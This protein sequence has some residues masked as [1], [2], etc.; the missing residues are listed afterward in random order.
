M[1]SEG[2]DSVP[3]LNPDSYVGCIIHNSFST[4]RKVGNVRRLNAI[5]FLTS[6]LVLSL[7]ALPLITN[8]AW[9][10]RGKLPR[11]IVF[12]L[13]HPSVSAPTSDSNSSSAT[14]SQGAVFSNPQ[15]SSTLANYN[16]QFTLKWSD[17][18]GIIGYI[19]SYDSG[20]GIFVNDSYVSTWESYQRFD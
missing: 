8:S 3:I 20:S 4:E 12:S 7:V 15:V 18:S 11:R 14:S 10:A 16:T 17:P 6:L 9:N 19:F 2:E 13:G 5:R 1:K